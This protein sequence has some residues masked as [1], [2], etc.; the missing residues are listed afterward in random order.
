M[1]KKLKDF[2]A[3]TV[4]ADRYVYHEATDSFI[5]KAHRPLENSRN[6]Q[7]VI[8][9]DNAL[10]KINEQWFYWCAAT[11]HASLRPTLETELWKSPLIPIEERMEIADGA[12]AFRNETIRHLHKRLVSPTIQEFKLTDELIEAILD[13][14]YEV[15]D[16]DRNS[17]TGTIKRPYQISN[18]FENRDLGREV[19][20]QVVEALKQITPKVQE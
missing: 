6:R 14:T 10:D 9:H 15:E 18:N 1:E 3:V 17:E 13:T 20:Q 11:E 8:D 2:L 12:I 7:A 19:I 16:F 4:G 5:A